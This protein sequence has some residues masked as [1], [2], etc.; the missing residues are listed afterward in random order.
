MTLMK[1]HARVLDEEIEGLDSLDTLSSRV[2]DQHLPD[3]AVGPGHQNYSLCDCHT[4]CKKK[5]GA[6]AYRGSPVLLSSARASRPPVS[7]RDPTAS[8]N[9]TVAPDLSPT[10]ARSGDELTAWAR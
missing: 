5:Y 8:R 2:L 9:P 3:A 1:I 7:N 4:P 10:A 6:P